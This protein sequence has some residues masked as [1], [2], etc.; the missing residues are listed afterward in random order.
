MLNRCVELQSC[1]L[2]EGS[3]TH[4]VSVMGT[5]MQYMHVVFMMH[6]G[7]TGARLCVTSDSACPPKVG[8]IRKGR[9][10]SQ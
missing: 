5:P 3:R 8:H 9:G 4:H 1:L 10:A 6:R 2:V 7:L